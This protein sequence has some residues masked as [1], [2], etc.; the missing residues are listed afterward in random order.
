M[1]DEDE[2][3]WESNAQRIPFKCHML[4]GSCAGVVEH[5]IVFPLDTVKTSM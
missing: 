3:D 5:T 4:A 2:L 1:V